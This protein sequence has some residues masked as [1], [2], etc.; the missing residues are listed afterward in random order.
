MY[1]NS[2]LKMLPLIIVTMFLHSCNAFKSYPEKDSLIRG[3]PISIEP[4][5]RGYT[6]TFENGAKMIEVPK[7][8]I[9]DSVFDIR[10]VYNHRNKLLFVKYKKGRYYKYYVSNDKRDRSNRPN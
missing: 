10:E 3:K 8:R 6:L 2:I 5:A 9:K 1:K 4:G 7:D